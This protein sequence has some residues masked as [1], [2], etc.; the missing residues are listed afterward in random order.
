[1]ESSSLVEA[2]SKEELVYYQE[3]FSVFDKEDKGTIPTSQFAMF[4][5]GLGHCPTEAELTQMKHSLDP[6]NE[7]AI[8]FAS[9][10]SAI[11]RRPREQ[12][13]EE[14]LMEA[15]EGIQSESG[16]LS[17][18]DKSFKMSVK[19]ARKMLMELGEALSEEEAEKFQ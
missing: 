17:D 14:E 8:P 15:F 13:I 2:L 5:R 1:M 18:G 12:N 6:N 3:L 9:I 11:L 19:E 16:S 7:G 10:L 4:M